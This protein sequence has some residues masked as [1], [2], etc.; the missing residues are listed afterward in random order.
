M[1]APRRLLPGIDDNRGRIRI[2]TVSRSIPIASN[3]MQVH[4]IKLF[5]N[6]SYRSG[7][8]WGTCYQS[9][10]QGCEDLD[11]LFFDLHHGFWCVSGPG[12]FSKGL[13]VC[14]YRAAALCQIASLKN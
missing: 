14:W 12:V 3:G 4:E 13:L 1:K 10:G 8:I 2:I 7:P 6:W 11:S 5:E 9:L